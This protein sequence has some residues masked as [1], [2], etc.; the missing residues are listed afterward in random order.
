MPDRI[1][2]ERGAVTVRE[3][4]SANETGLHFEILQD[5]G[6]DNRIG[7]PRIQKLGLALAGFTGYIHPDRVQMMGASEINYLKLLDPAARVE[8]LERLAGL[9][10][11]CIVLLKGLDAPEGL[12]ELGRRESIPVLR[13]GAV[14]SL[15]VLKIADYLDSRLAPRI[16]VHGVFLE[17][18][19]LGVLLLGP[20]GI[21]KSEC[22]LEL[23]LKGHRL[24]ADDAVELTRRGA[25]RLV[26]CGGEVLRYH[27]EL[28]GLGIINVKDLFGIS[29][30][31]RT[32]S[33]DLAVR[34]E[35]WR[36][37][38]EY[39]RLGLDEA[40]IEYLGIS[41]PLVVMPVAPGRNVATLV[42]TAARI[43]Q[44]RQRGYQPSRE[45]L[46]EEGGQLGTAG[47]E[48]GGSGATHR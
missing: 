16:T 3:F 44:L 13:T 20:S 43:Q 4:A 17:V 14:S 40:R 35:R 22:A 38:A 26:G 24:I 9:R 8:A 10:I 5:D 32:H 23:I 18:F 31:G 36:P 12:I 19:E 45:L 48:E 1:P 34:L 27:I 41:V 7:S 39:D 42:E 21:G 46:Q 15:A 37:D 33:L 29:A 11:C 47:G 30:T 25:E 2:Q 28:R 6:I